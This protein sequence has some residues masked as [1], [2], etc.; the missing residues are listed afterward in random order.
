MKKT[1]CL[2]F[3][4]KNESHCIIDTLNSVYKYLDYWVICDTGSDDNTCELIENFFK[5]KNIPGEL[6]RDDFID[7]GTN[8]SL[9]ML[10][11]KN[12]SD[13]IFHIDADDLVIGDMDTSFLNSNADTYLVNTKRHNTFYKAQAFFKGQYLWKFAGVAHTIVINQEK[14][15]VSTEILENTDW[16]AL[17]QDLGARKADPAK[18]AKEAKRLKKQFFDTLLDDVD[19]INSRSVFYTAQSYFDCA[20]YEEAM[21]WYS[22]YIRMKYTWIEEIY[23]SHLRIAVCMTLL[24]YDFDRVKAELD[25]AINIFVDRAEAYYILGRYANEKLKSEIA[26]QNLLICKSC[27]FEQI[28]KKYLLFIS[29]RNYGKFVNDELSVA[30]YWTGRYE[31]G[32]KLIHEIIDD[33]DFTDHKERL[34]KNLNY[35]KE[36]YQQMS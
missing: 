26:Y 8:K 20:N 29:P 16:Y 12:K 5:E 22:L 19:G 35:L 17:S 10:R 14:T 15:D 36:N 4:C 11:A 9:M 21:K 34:L 18:Y 7:M 30:C 24:N 13:Y 1:I 27:D 25:K 6:Y 28:R 33:E 32:I 3:I 2:S 31:E 23:E